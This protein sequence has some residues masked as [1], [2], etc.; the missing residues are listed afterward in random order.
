MD[1]DDKKKMGDAK[2][3]LFKRVRKGLMGKTS[4]SKKLAGQVEEVLNGKKPAETNK[5]PKQPRKE[6]KE[7]KQ[8]KSSKKR[9]DPVQD[10]VDSINQTD[11]GLR[12]VEDA[13]RE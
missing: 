7:P 2:F 13:A 5:E 1:K 3:N 9:E 11:S 4:E 12:K 6:P 8:E 10:A